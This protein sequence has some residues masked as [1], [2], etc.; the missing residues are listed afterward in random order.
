MLISGSNRLL[1]LLTTHNAPTNHPP[2]TYCVWAIMHEV[3]VNLLRGENSDL[4]SFC[5]N[6]HR[7][8]SYQ[9]EAINLDQLFLVRLTQ[10]LPAPTSSSSDDNQA[11]THLTPVCA[12]AVTK[13]KKRA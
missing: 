5:R 4:D 8:G 1:L 9:L 10:V 3:D 6:T 13:R 11:M 2:S 7:L 12:R